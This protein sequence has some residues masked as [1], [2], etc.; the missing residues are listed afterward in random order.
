ML[1]PVS[2]KPDEV[3]RQIQDSKI[4]SQV[5]LNGPILGNPSINVV[6]DSH[7]FTVK[8]LISIM[9]L[10]VTNPKTQ[11]DQLSQLYLKQK[12][13]LITVIVDAEESAASVKRVWDEIQSQRELHRMKHL[14]NLAN[15]QKYTVEVKALPQA[16]NQSGTIVCG[17]G[18]MHIEVVEVPKKLSKQS[19][20]CA[21]NIVE[22]GSDSKQIHV[23]TTKIKTSQATTVDSNDTLWGTPW[24]PS[25]NDINQ[26][27]DHDMNLS[28]HSLETKTK[29]NQF[30]T[31]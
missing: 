3:K 27:A 19:G 5:N 10:L 17:G 8:E 25:D 24:K 31:G 29:P 26:M 20:L 6:M 2:R 21:K 13:S 18:E 28:S 9:E 23:G 15:T 30:S 14:E 1:N 22:S 16:I 4:L 7:F 12:E 11:F